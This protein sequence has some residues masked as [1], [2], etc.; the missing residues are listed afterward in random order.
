MITGKLTRRL[1][2][3]ALAVSFSCSVWAAPYMDDKPYKQPAVLQEFLFK[4]PSVSL[5][6]PSFEDSKTDFT[7]QEEMLNYIKKLEE[8][9]PYL[10]V[11]NIGYSQEGREIPML[12]FQKGNPSNKP[13]VWLQAQ[14][15]GNEP[16]AGEAVLAIARNLA[17]GSLAQVLDKINVIIIPR[18]NPDGSYYFERRTAN[19]LQDINRDNVKFELPE[20][21]LVHKAYNKVKAEVVLD[22]HE[23]SV[24]T[25][26]KDVGQGHLAYYDLLLL[27]STNANVPKG[28]TELAD[29]LLINNAGKEIEQS[30]H[31]WHWYYI[32]APSQTHAK[33]I[34]MADGV[35][36]I[37]RN[38][39]GLQPAISILIESRGIGIGKQDFKR[40]VASQYITYASMLRNVAANA[41]EIK[42]VVGNAR[43][44]IIAK[45]DNVDDAATDKIVILTEPKPIPDFHLKL[46][47]LEDKNVANLPMEGYT[48]KDYT[49]SLERVRPYAYIIPAAFKPLAEKLAHSGVNVQKTTAPLML[50]VES[51]KIT[52]NKVSTKYFEGH[53]RNTVK[54][55]VSNSNV[56]F[57]SGSYVVYMGQ[58]A[59]N[60]AAMCL[61]PESQASFVTFNL[62]P[63]EKGD[64]VPTYRLMSKE[65]LHTVAAFK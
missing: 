43:A 52:D 54:T 39:Y 49:V 14:V 22:A 23:Y 24:A 15:H 37:G 7:T 42:D 25:P 53:F 38:A 41:Q 48:Q 3:L 46:V 62:I 47:S 27:S 65:Q 35:P 59:A 6:T 26:Y 51:Y 20:T 63:V 2:P 44:E 1:L 32:T 5:Q 64:T 61:E 13:T 31:T 28:I 19:K 40:R 9:A 21:V 17:T 45:G 58:P 18:I 36:I 50:D 33:K 8:H 11:S 55:T 57:P 4:E 60:L 10:K 34:I 56:W 16:A 29:N 12:T 30:G